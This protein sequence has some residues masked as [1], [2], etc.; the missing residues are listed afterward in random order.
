MKPK[1]AVIGL[2]GLP[3]YGGAATVG[4]AIINELKDKY[5][6]YIYSIST[7]TKKNNTHSGYYQIVFNE[8]KIN[9][10]ATFKYYVKAMLHCIFIANYDL[11]HLHHSTTG[12]ITPFLRLKYK[13]ILTLHGIVADN[14]DPKFNKVTNIFFR[15]S[16]KMN[17]IFANK[18]VSV[19]KSG[20]IFCEK[21]YNK[22]IEYIPNG[23]NN[24]KLQ[25]TSSTKSSCF[26]FIAARIY[27]IKG[28]HLLLQAIKKYNIAGKL[29]VIGDLDQQENYKNI[30]LNMAEGL[31]VEFVPLIKDKDKLFE[32]VSKSKIFIFPSLHEAMSMTLL[33]VV[34]LKIPV[35]ASD[36]EANKNIFTSDEV[37]FFKSGDYDDLANKLIYCLD[38]YDLIDEKTENA[39]NLVFNNYTWPKISEQYSKLFNRLLSPGKTPL[40]FTLMTLKVLLESLKKRD[41]T[42][43]TFTGYIEGQEMNGKEQNKQT[44]VD[45]S[46]IEQTVFDELQPKLCILRHDIDRMAENSLSIAKIEYEMGIRGSYYFRVVPESFNIH[47]MKQV[48]EMGHEIGYHYEDVDLVSKKYKVKRKKL[49][50]NELIDLSYASFC[51]N[52]EMFRQDFD[53]KTVC[54]H[55]SPR[56]NYDNKIIW[57]KYDYRDLG[58]IGEPYLDINFD[59]FAYFTDTGRRWNADKISIRDKVK[60]KY[61]FNLKTTHQMIDNIETLPEKLMINIHTNRWSDFGIDWTREL[62]V[63][64][65]KN[66]VKYYFFNRK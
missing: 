9:G 51:K 34:S 40:D 22:F 65:L 46:C 29:I 64:N 61:H 14:F 39:F 58:I 12:F 26:I 63:Q 21:N 47:V 20:K 62:V 4:E 17:M 38:N 16:E 35:L 24:I 41:Y 28:L 15:I 54:M 42:F 7:H 49:S 27:E 57:E 2:K 37:T 6:F 45:K 52:L 10:L 18:I 60:S 13:V 19:S 44:L 66:I 43:L 25:N 36:I 30:I 53:V 55:G 3:A 48:A 32:Y 33:E 11:I 23:V 5:D 8:K 59:I 50:R 56:S 1:I 31:D